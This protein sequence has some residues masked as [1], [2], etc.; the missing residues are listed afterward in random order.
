MENNQINTVPVMLTVD[1][2]A[3]TFNLA[4]HF[5]RQ[6]AANG[7]IV[8]IHAGR[9]LLINAQ[10]LQQYLNTGIPQGHIIDTEQPDAPQSRIAKIPAKI[11]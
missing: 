8:A 1:E 5:V 11:K 4:K 10:S 6:S 7:N 3:K 2:A 9:K